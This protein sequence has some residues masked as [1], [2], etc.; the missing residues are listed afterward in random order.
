MNTMI[1]GIILLVT[2]IGIPAIFAYRTD[3]V[4]FFELLKI[5]S[6]CAIWAALVCLAI[7]LIVW[8]GQ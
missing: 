6:I 5:V 3:R 1:I 8:R 2:L 4:A 7:V